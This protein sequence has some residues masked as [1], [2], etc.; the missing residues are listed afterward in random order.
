MDLIEARD[1]AYLQDPP[2]D[3]DPTKRLLERYSLIP[4]DQVDHHIRVIVS[5]GIF[6][7][8]A[9][10][11]I[12]LSAMPLGRSRGIPTSGDGNSFDCWILMILDTSKHCSG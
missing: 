1:W 4:R 6:N 3:V 2:S 10:T 9:L 7:Y 12:L 11:D 8:S 5:L